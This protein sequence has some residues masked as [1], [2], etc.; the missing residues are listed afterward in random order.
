[1]TEVFEVEFVRSAPDVLTSG[2]LY[3]S[4]EHA[5]VLH[6]CACGCGHQVV[7]ELSPMHYTLI[8]DGEGITLNPSVG[9]W[10]LPCRSHYL[11]RDSHVAWAATWSDAR[12][13]TGRARQALRLAA[14]NAKGAEVAEVSSARPRRH[15]WWARKSGKSQQP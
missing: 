9:N 5:A 4:M 13:A 11:I 6:L 15:W 8:Y 12:V 10:S 14:H 7:L 2:V 1:M 3:V